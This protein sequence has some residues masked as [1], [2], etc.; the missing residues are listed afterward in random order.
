MLVLHLKTCFACNSFITVWV[1]WITMKMDKTIQKR[2]RI[3][4]ILDSM[5]FSKRFFS[6]MCRVTESSMYIIHERMIFLACYFVYNCWKCAF[7]I[8]LMADRKCQSWM[9]LFCT[10]NALTNIM[11]TKIPK[12]RHLSNLCAIK[13]IGWN[14]YR[15]VRFRIIQSECIFVFFESLMFFP[16]Q[17]IYCVS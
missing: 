5:E 16:G 9:S 10:R 2:N 13:F 4:K 12:I 3:K 1:S 8:I 6:E 17:N 15:C 14:I 7:D 11:S